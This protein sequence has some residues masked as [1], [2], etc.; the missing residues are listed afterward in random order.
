[1]GLETTKYIA[2]LN[3]ANPA[4]DDAKSQGDDHL[5]MLKEV[6]QICFGGFGGSVLLGGT[7]TG[8]ANTYALSFT[9]TIPGYVKNTVIA[10]AASATNTGAATLNVSGLG[11]RNITQADGSA[12]LPGDIPAG[13]FILLVDDGTQY[14]L[15]GVTKNY[16]DQMAFGSAFPNPPA[17]GV[18]YVATALGGLSSWQ[19]NGRIRSTRTASATIART[20]SGKYIVITG[21]GNIRQALP[22]A[23]SIGP[24]FSFAYTNNSAGDVEIEAPASVTAT[25]STSNTVGAGV[26][27]TLPAG[28]SI[29]VGDY[30]NV[31]RTS[32]PFSRRIIAKAS[33]YD[34]VT[35]ALTIS[36]TGTNSEFYRVGAGAAPAQSIVSIQNAGT[37]ATLATSAEHGLFTSE[38]VTVSGAIAANYNGT[39]TITVPDTPAVAISSLVRSGTLATVTTTTPHGLFTNQLVTVS[40]VTPAGFNGTYAIAVTGTSTFTYTMAVDP[41][42]DATVVGAYTAGRNIFQYTMASAPPG[43]ATVLGSYTVSANYTDWTVTSRPASMLVDGRQSYVMYPGETREFQCD[44]QNFSSVVLAAYG[45]RKTASHIYIKPPGYKCHTVRALGGGAGG[46]GGGGGAS[47]SGTGGSLGGAGGSGGSSGGQGKVAQK[48]VADADM[49]VSVPVVVGSGS[50]GGAGGAG[51]SVAVGSSGLAGVVGSASAAGGSTIFGLT[52]DA[53]YVTAAG[54]AAAN[55]GGPGQTGGIGATAPAAPAAV[56]GVLTPEAITTFGSAAGNTSA[57]SS[58]TAGLAGT[59]GT[60]G[61]NGTGSFVAPTATTSP[62]TAGAGSA[63]GLTPTAGGNAT[64]TARPGQGGAGGGGGG[65]SGTGNPNPSAAGGNGG[66]GADG[67]SGQFEAYGG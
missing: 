63:A 55:P 66:R 14:R 23:S 65:G 29:A 20:D 8:P 2:G 4:P 43:N 48:T 3:R 51:G 18:T 50:A 47:G 1:M 15:L 27:W 59:N 32:D 67:G 36:L 6:L 61:A 5:R 39:F 34:S 52:T 37:L 58:S 16:V 53:S 42:A 46:G 40:G 38:T 12:L 25:S 57:S 24:N 64:G 9:P 28:L 41:G 56:A 10:W 35:G 62:G 7:A 22:L 49:P 19:Y 13:Q 21:A 45:V 44:G 30:V 31:R 26:T 17:D 11:P 60:A 33:A 54:G